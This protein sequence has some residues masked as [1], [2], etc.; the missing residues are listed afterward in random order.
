MFVFVCWVLNEHHQ[1][2]MKVEKTPFKF[3]RNFYHNIIISNE[4]DVYV[5]FL[6]L[7]ILVLD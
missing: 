3:K 6:E 1:I 4:N 7:N 5:S 2:D